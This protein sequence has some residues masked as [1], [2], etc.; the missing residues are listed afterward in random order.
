MSHYC[1][2][3]MLELGLKDCELRHW[4]GARFECTAAVKN[5]DNPCRSFVRFY[6]KMPAISSEYLK[7]TRYFFRGFMKIKTMRYC[8]SS[9]SISDSVR[10]CW[11]HGKSEALSKWVS[12]F[13]FSTGSLI[14]AGF[15]LLVPERPV[16]TRCYS[17]KYFDGAVVILKKGEAWGIPFFKV[18]DKRGR[19]EN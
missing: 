18:V 4:L 17:I 15:L 6:L 19:V 1:G 7:K 9:I 16:N 5:K 13:C 10:A 3:R 2:L 11:Q 12:L 14:I 8:Y